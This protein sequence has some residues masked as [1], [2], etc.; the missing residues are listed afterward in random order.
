MTKKTPIWGV[1]NKCPAETC[2]KLLF[3]N[4][5]DSGLY[6]TFNMISFLVHFKYTSHHS[7]PVLKYLQTTEARNVFY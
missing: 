2:L 6:Y 7:E 5:Y 4:A 3:M 1:R